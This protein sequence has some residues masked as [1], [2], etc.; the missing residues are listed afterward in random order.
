MRATA[1]SNDRWG[2]SMRGLVGVGCSDERCQPTYMQILL[3]YRSSDRGEA[4]C[5]WGIGGGLDGWFDDDGGTFGVH[6]L[7]VEALGSKALT[8]RLSLRAGVS[9]VV[10]VHVHPVVMLAWRF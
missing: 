7:A 5:T 1:W 6:L 3:R 2:V 9:A 10:P 8:D 4:A